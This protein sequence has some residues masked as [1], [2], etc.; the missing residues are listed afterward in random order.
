MRRVLEGEPEP[1]GFEKSEVFIALAL[2]AVGAA[3]FSLAA[4]WA[5]GAALLVCALAGPEKAGFLDLAFWLAWVPAGLHTGGWAFRTDREDI[6]PVIVTAAF[7]VSA[8]LAGIIACR[9][10]LPFAASLLV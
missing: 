2:T 4:C 10:I 7:V 5:A 6:H 9:W 1:G 8:A 3:A